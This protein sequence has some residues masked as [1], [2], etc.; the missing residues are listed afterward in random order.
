MIKSLQEARLADG[1]PRVLKDQPLVQ[2]LSEALGKTH[3][4]TMRF[5]DESQI[6]TELD[7]A[8]EPVL[9]AL[10][11]NWNIVW[12][13]NAFT[14]EQ[15]RRVVKSAITVRK[16]VGTAAAVK[17]QLNAI[18]P[19]TTVQ[20]WFEYGG[21]PGCFR[22]ESQAQKL[23]E[24][25]EQFLAA[26]N[27]VKRFSAQFDGISVRH[28]VPMVLRAGFGLRVRRKITIECEIPEGMN[29]TYLTNEAG[30]TLTNERGENLTI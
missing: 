1:L 2:A 7:T 10:A 18:W 11:A 23:A 9:D 16:M 21:E 27:A 25:P 26:L 15:K 12:Y 28:S 4:M 29:V 5:A 24:E 17:I 14:L 30:A 13:D 3:E 8:T 20:E 22:V 6:F 19:G